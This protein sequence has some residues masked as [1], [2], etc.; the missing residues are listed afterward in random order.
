MRSVE[1]AALGLGLGARDTRARIALTCF[2]IETRSSRHSSRC[3]P[4]LSINQV[5][6]VSIGWCYFDWLA[7]WR[8]VT[9]PASGASCRLVHARA[10]ACACV[11]TLS[12]RS[13]QLS[14]AQLTTIDRRAASD[15]TARIGR[16]CGVALAIPRAAVAAVRADVKS[17]Q[18]PRERRPHSRTR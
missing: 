17:W 16:A 2:R 14:S 5:D 18:Q 4:A 10:R 13:P 3:M 9:C 6:T 12:V 1:D 15:Q 11:S 7:G 8:C